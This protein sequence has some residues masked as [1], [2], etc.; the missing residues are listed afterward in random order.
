MSLW[1]AAA[2]L[3]ALCACPAE[4]SRVKMTMDEDSTGAGIANASAQ[5]SSQGWSSTRYCI[6]CRGGR[7]IY[8]KRSMNKMQIFGVAFSLAVKGSMLVLPHHGVAGAVY[9]TLDSLSKM[10]KVYGNARA[11]YDKIM[12]EVADEVT[13]V[14]FVWTDERNRI[15]LRKQDIRYFDLPQEA[16]GDDATDALLIFKKNWQN[17]WTN[18]VGCTFWN[19]CTSIGMHRDSMSPFTLDLV[20]E[21]D[22]L[23]GGEQK[24][25][26]H[27]AGVVKL[28]TDWVVDSHEERKE[29]MTCLENGYYSRR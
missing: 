25:V 12:R 17:L 19:T 1:A 23:C 7:R 22:W 27:Y 4:T 10:S 24:G 5:I 20:D 29:E 18:E 8:I 14:S 9:W 15:Q 21:H 28:H 16:T 26:S 11:I 3:F 2:I 6:H 13:Y